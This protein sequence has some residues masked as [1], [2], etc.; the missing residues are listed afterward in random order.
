MQDELGVRLCDGISGSVGSCR[1]AC[2]CAFIIRFLSSRGCPR[3]MITTISSGIVH[4]A[5]FPLK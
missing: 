4:S 3:F 1:D 2:S 5:F